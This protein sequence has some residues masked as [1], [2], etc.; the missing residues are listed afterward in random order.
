M[1][2]RFLTQT[3]RPPGYALGIV[4]PIDMDPAHAPLVRRRLSELT[5]RLANVEVLVMGLKLRLSWS[6]VGGVEVV[7]GAFAR[8]Y[9]Y[10]V[11]VYREFACRKARAGE[12]PTPFDPAFFADARAFVVFDD[13]HPDI[14]V[15]LQMAAGTGKRV[16]RIKLPEEP[17]R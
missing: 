11:R 9:W 16:K 8:R 13:G 12:P 2:K 6:V 15:W 3:G 14:A 17:E 1:P 4:G 10:D 5:W 7:A